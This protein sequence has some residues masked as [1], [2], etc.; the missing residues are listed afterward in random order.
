MKDVS[1]GEA[2]KNLEQ[3]TDQQSAARR[4]RLIIPVSDQR[5]VP[6]V[7]SSCMMH[8]LSSSASPVIPGGPSLAS[9]G[10]ICF[11]LRSMIPAVVKKLLR[12]RTFVS[13][14]RSLPK[15]PEP[16]L[17]LKCNMPQSSLSRP[18]DAA[19]CSSP[20]SSV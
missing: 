17:T 1:L 15:P 4:F 9:G 11:K 13:A 20:R 7:L 8:L 10:V 19:K 2:R 6:I 5:F 16:C 14:S 3:P 12:Y 18:L